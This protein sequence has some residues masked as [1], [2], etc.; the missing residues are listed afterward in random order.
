MKS[1]SAEFRRLWGYSVGFYGVWIAH[2]GRQTGLLEQIS[3]K[4]LT[5]KDLASSTGLDLP[6][7][8]AWASAAESYGFVTKKRNGILDIAPRMADLLLDRSHPEYLGGQMSYLALRSLEFGKFAGLFRRGRTHPIVSNFEA[9]EEATHWDHFA[10]LKAIKRDRGLDLRLRKGCRFLDVGCGTGSLIAKL[11]GEYQ[12]TSFV[13][14][15]PSKKAI[16]QA[17]RLL[18]GIA[19]KLEIMEAEKMAFSNEFDIAY[20]GES[21]YAARNRQKAIDN[22]FRA[23]KTKGIIAV[24]EG[25]LPSS[26]IQNSENKLI[27]GMQLDFALQGH[28][29]LTRKEILALLKKSDFTNMRLKSLGGAVYLITARKQ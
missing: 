26:R 11:K 1:R 10:F 19:V 20:L 6:A 8:Q 22:C 3:R 13:G 25:L 14:I 2:I 29:F 18:R 4:T 21:L 28:N 5:V 12:R 7:V 15:D 24:V 16:R 27:M 23:L 17:Q 9:I